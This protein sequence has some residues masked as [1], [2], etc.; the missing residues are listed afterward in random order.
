[1]STDIFNGLKLNIIFFLLGGIEGGFLLPAAAFYRFLYTGEATAHRA[2]YDY[3]RIRVRQVI[4]HRRR[5]D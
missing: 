4:R 5:L 1:M 2:F 3:F